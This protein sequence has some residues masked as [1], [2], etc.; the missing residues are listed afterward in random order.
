MPPRNEETEAQ[1][2]AFNIVGVG[3]S[4]G[5]VEALSEFLTGLS[6]TPG[7][8]FLLVLHRDPTHASLLVDILSKTTGVP[9]L[10][11]QDG[12]T[13]EIDHVYVIPAMCTV[14]AIDTVL[15]LHSHDTPEQRRIPIDSMFK[16]MAENHG[17]NSIG[18]VLSGT[19]SDGAL[20]IQEIKGAGG[21]TFAQ[22]PA[23]A[24]FGVMP[25][26]A[27]ETG[28]VDFVLTP[29]E[30]AEKILEIGKHPYLNRDN[31][32]Q[33]EQPYTDENSLKKIFRLLRTQAQV[34][35]SQ[36]KRSTI[37]RRLERRMA[38]RQVRDL[39]QYADLMRDDGNEVQALVQD[40][41][42]QVTS[43]FRDSEEFKGLA[44]IVF[45]KLVE[46]RSQKE[47]LRI[48]IP[49]CATGEEAYSVAILLTEF[50]VDRALT[51]PIQI[52][53]TDLSEIAVRQARAGE[54]VSNIEREVSSERLRRFFV[55][56]DD[57]YQISKPIRDLCVFARHNV[58]YDPPF[59]RIDLICCRNVLIYFDLDLQGKVLR[60][61]HYALKSRG[62]LELGPSESISQSAEL[63]QLVDTHYRIYRKQDAAAALE[64]KPIERAGSSATIPSERAGFA[65][66]VSAPELPRVQRNIERLLARY[67]P[68]TVVVDEGLNIIHFQGET[69]PFL[70]HAPGSASF[71]LQKVVRTGLMMEVSSA[72]EQA[73]K[74]GTPARR[75]RIR[76]EQSGAVST[77]NI[78][79]VP[80][81]VP[82]SGGA[83]YALFFEK[84]TAPEAPGLGGRLARWSMEAFR[85][86]PGASN[87]D[88]DR[89]QQLQ[90]ELEAT[91]EYLHNAIE[92]HEAA[93]EELKAA[94]EEALSASE[95][96]QS[97]NEELETAKEELQSTNEE[98]STTNEE[99]RN[100]NF[101]LNDTNEA[102]RMARD[103][104]NAIYETM[105]E[106]LLVLDSELRVMEA[107]SAFYETFK[108]SRDKTENRLIYELGNGQWNIP[109]LRHLLEEVLPNHAPVHD[110]EMSH[111]FPTIGA[112][113]MRLNAHRLTG[114]GHI[115]LALQD[116]TDISNALAALKETDRQKDQFLAM[117]SH[118]LRNPLAPIANALQIILWMVRRSWS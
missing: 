36:Y 3:A 93:L 14:A 32:E 23:S 80:L 61:F 108:T 91:R 98:L 12:M 56:L 31:A 88:K 102:L 59:S 117:L 41:L 85:S 22:E 29:K 4:A 34:D 58:T 66:T 64:T 75:E 70:D 9:V 79:V 83:L 26:K 45:P 90:R 60:F 104:F 50:L 27:I 21:I 49:G 11:A 89:I 43:F 115:L 37:Q 67:A 95:E 69:G 68:A 19:G 99:L 76:F 1:N 57:H 28:C 113:T 62:F 87:A 44:E 63:F 109:K 46:N 92:E 5:G 16:A 100:R 8:A 38:L 25:S 54:Y 15:H 97:T 2:T 112:R 82:D 10:E 103:K 65:E 72:I 51:I 71:N 81:N 118:E 17:S 7:M 55:K 40:L 106:P 20:G 96:F 39:A 52:F 107:N 73:R 35:F 86:G 77:A 74:R 110:F 78:E 6:A 18:V 84:A 42:I 105:Q 111:A 53:G 116:I 33:E 101:Q 30:I 24:R 48:W 13:L 94:H 114:N 47:S